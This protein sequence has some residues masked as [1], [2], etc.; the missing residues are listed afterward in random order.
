MNLLVCQTEVAKVRDGR[1]P[2][3]RHSALEADAML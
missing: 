3:S 1:V 2:D